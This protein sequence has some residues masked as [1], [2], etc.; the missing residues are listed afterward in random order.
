[1]H[2]SP[3]ILLIGAIAPLAIAT[4]VPYFRLPFRRSTGD[5]RPW[6]GAIERDWN[7]TLDLPSAEVPKKSTVESPPIVL[8]KNLDETHPYFSFLRKLVKRD[9]HHVTSIRS[10][11]DETAKLPI[12]IPLAT[13]PPG[14]APPPPESPPAPKPE[15]LAEVF[16]P[17]IYTIKHKARV[18]PAP[19]PAP[20]SDEEKRQT[21]YQPPPAGATWPTVSGVAGAPPAPDVTTNDEQSEDEDHRASQEG[22]EANQ[23]PPGHPVPEGINSPSPAEGE[24]FPIIGN[25]RRA[26]PTLEELQRKIRNMKIDSPEDVEEAKKLVREMS[27]LER[28][29]ER[30]LKRG[31]VMT[32]EQ[33]RTILRSKTIGSALD[34]EEVKELARETS[35]TEERGRL[36]K[37]SNQFEGSDIVGP[38]DAAMAWKQSIHPIGKTERGRPELK[39]MET[40]VHEQP[41]GKRDSTTAPAEENKSETSTAQTLEE[42]ITEAAPVDDPNPDVEIKTTAN[43]KAKENGPYGYGGYQGGGGGYYPQGGF[44]YGGYQG[45]GSNYYP[46]GGFNNFPGGGRGGYGYGGRGNYKE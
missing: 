27:L 7:G 40:W 23:M 13:P 34:V 11:A 9:S 4:P 12:P 41:F 6:D 21:Q 38:G 28:Q 20:A 35:E 30:E 2:Y 8:H 44:G 24:S 5:V 36:R 32:A 15:F 25:A 19:T 14:T 43:T 3:S 16:D 1:M 37:R 29:G 45:G 31:V 26:T 18:A 46:N 33:I 39:G 22:P 10:T 17:S 42:K